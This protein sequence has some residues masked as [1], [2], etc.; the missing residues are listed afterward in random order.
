MAA[1]F[2]GAASSFFSPEF[3][4]LRSKVRRRRLL[5]SENE[6]RCVV[7][8]RGFAGEAVPPS[9]G[10]RT[11]GGSYHDS[12]IIDYL[13]SE[14]HPEGRAKARFFR[15]LG[16]VRERPA[17]LSAALLELAVRTDM[18]ETTFRFGRKYAGVGFMA[19]PNG[20]RRGVL[21]I[22]MLIGGMPPPVLVTAYPA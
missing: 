8:L 7:D 2:I 6:Q 15:S 1:P 10:S 3:Q 9:G 17:E 19:G 5:Y 12:K 22:W 4:G 20:N 14:V 21:T 13:L 18:T 16:F 11:S